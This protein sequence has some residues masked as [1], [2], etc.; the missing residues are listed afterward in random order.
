MKTNWLAI[1]FTL[2]AMSNLAAQKD[3]SAIRRPTWA[4]GIYGSVSVGYGAFTQPFKNPGTVTPYPSFAASGMVFH[5]DFGVSFRKRWG[6]RATASAYAATDQRAALELAA[7]ALFPGYIVDYAPI[8]AF[9]NKTI[10][11][12][13]VGVSY[14]F[15]HRRW[16]F[17]PE[18]L[19]GSTEVYGEWATLQAK[20]LGTNEVVVWKLR[21]KDYEY[22]S[23]TI[24]LGGRAAWQA[25]WY[26]GLFADVRLNTMLYDMEYQ[27][28]KTALIEQSFEK[29][30]IRLKRTALG[31]T[32]SVG[33]L[34]QIARWER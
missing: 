20:A 1:L 23:P 3:S 4:A 27:I 28:D 19:L 25:G 30:T 33:I 5:W 17:Q 11:H 2:A 15:P 32:A 34:L 14:A 21:P 18:V 9:N 31:A 24:T 10:N 12:F 29:E 7:R 22:R 6:L 13:A 8:T 26:W 16:Y